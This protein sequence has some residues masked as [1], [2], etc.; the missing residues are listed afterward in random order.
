MA[1]VF[2]QAGLAPE[3]VKRQAQLERLRSHGIVLALARVDDPEGL[4]TGRDL[5]FGLLQGFE[6]DR[7]LATPTPVPLHE[8]FNPNA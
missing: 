8:P 1:K 4:A 2:W 6:I 7:Q 5:R 3:L